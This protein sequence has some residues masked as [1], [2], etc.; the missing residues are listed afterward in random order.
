MSNITSLL[1]CAMIALSFQTNAFLK[2]NDDEDP[3]SLTPPVED[4]PPVEGEEPLPDHEY[5][6]KRDPNRDTIIGELLPGEF[7]STWATG[8]VDYDTLPLSNM[9]DGTYDNT[10]T[11]NGFCHKTV[12]DDLIRVQLQISSTDVVSSVALENLSK[13]YKKGTSELMNKF[14]LQSDMIMSVMVACNENT[15]NNEFICKNTF[16]IEL[17]DLT[18]AMKIVDYS[19]E[20]KN[21]VLKSIIYD[22]NPKTMEKAREEC[23]ATAM[24]NA[25]KSADTM[26]RIINMKIYEDDPILKS[27]IL[28]SDIKPMVEENSTNLPEGQMMNIQISAIFNLAA[29]NS[30]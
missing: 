23:I 2:T 28:T 24:D 12:V 20:G 29:I 26:A 13:E 17:T 15:D 22:F 3:N 8:E 11:V 18:K 30:S 16:E 1:F 6:S 10:I 19:K 4:T 27:T 25:R 14:E 9:T 21:V 7:N 5:N